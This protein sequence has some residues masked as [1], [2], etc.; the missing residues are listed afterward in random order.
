[1][2]PGRLQEM[3]L[4][5][6]LS[7][8]WLRISKVKV[9]TCIW[10]TSSPTLFSSLWDVSIGA[11]GTLHCNHVGVPTSI[12]NPPTKISLVKKRENFL[13][14]KWKDK[15]E[16]TLLTSLHDDT[17]IMKRWRT[18]SVVGVYE[19]IVKPQAIE[20]YNKYMAGVDKLEQ[21][22]SYYNFN[23]CT[24][25]EK[26]F[27]YHFWIFQSQMHT[28]IQC[29]KVAGWH[30]FNFESNWPRNCCLWKHHILHCLQLHPEFEP[31]SSHLF[32]LQLV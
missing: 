3:E 12:K 32:L 29:K 17:T 7:C 11:C 25:V 10:T 13:F 15:R 4:R 5:M 16:V 26:R 21:Y 23:R 30:S 14:L 1:M 22:L 6:T 8:R 31:F 24:M 9:I 27:S 19:E 28:P 18:S 20:R 2:H